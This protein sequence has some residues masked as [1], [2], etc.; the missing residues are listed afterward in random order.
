M[1]GTQESDGNAERDE[2]DGEPGPGEP[3]GPEDEDRKSPG[4]PGSQITPEVEP[5]G[6]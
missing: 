4:G 1:S 2:A 5:S 3:V 6:S